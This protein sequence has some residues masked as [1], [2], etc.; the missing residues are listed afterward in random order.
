ME[1]L[2]FSVI[3]IIA[4]ISLILLVN[5]IVKSCPRWSGSNR[6]AGELLR[7][8]LTYEQYR[9]LIR[10]GYID[11]PSPHDQE[12]TYRVPQSPGLVRVIEKGRRKASLCLQPL[13]RVPDAD[14][15][16]IHKLMIEADEETYL[17]TANLIAPQC[18]GD[19]DD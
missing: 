6:R 9:Q 1:T 13:E 7:A 18:G 10:Q 8:V 11:I 3:G 12:R 17:Q 16:V 15:V 5:F 4:D 2:A 19:W 14:I